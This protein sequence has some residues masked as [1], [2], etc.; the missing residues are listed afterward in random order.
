MI[1]ILK[2]SIYVILSLSSFFLVVLLFKNDKTKF[3]KEAVINSEKKF[4]NKTQIEKLIL[5]ELEVDSMIK[6]I[7]TIEKNILLNPY[8]KKLKLYQDL[9]NRLL[10]DIVQFNPIARIVSEKDKDLYVDLDG[11]IFPTSIK[12]SERVILIHI[13]DNLNFNFRNINSTDFGQK[14]FS[15]IIY[16]RNNDF[17]KRI[18]SEIDIKE[19]KNI[20]IYPQVSKQKIIFGYP[21]KIDDKFN[22]LIFFYK[23]I[24][25]A[26]GW[27]TYRSVNLKF[28]NQIVCNKNA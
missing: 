21:V 22:K 9:N 15:L 16:I 26:K 19:D 17:L 2:N 4:L 24:L 3:I 27:N 13:D 6:N 1:K 8:V 25:P 10:V 20:I 28:E 12:F 5:Q 23:K 18:I 11:N 7:N 14:I